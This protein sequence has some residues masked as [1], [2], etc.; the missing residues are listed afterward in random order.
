MSDSVNTLSPLKKPAALPTF[1][2]LSVLFVEDDIFNQHLTG[3]ILSRSGC[4]IA[5]AEHG[6]K[7]IDLISLNKFD[8]ILMDI[9]MPVLDGVQTT[10]IIREELGIKIPIIALTGDVLDEDLC[11]YRQAGMNAHLAKPYNQQQLLSLVSRYA[12]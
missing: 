1:K 9:T 2:G 6:R 11:R 12:V 3:L 7:A 4:N 8:L 10:K 5:I